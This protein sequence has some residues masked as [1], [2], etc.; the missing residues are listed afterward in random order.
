MGY[1]FAKG[2]DSYILASRKVLF[3]DELLEKYSERVNK[4]QMIL[5]GCLFF[6][7]FFLNNPFFLL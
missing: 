2:L 3:G 7:F 6:F 4:K 1:C 5:I